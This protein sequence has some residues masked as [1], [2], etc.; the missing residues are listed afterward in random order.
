MSTKISIKNIPVGYQSFISNGRHALLGDE[1]I[2][3]KGTELGFS[4][5]D[6]ILS[7]PAACTRS[8]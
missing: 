1:P 2:A 8:V 4:P 5:E 3:S 6:L 7:S